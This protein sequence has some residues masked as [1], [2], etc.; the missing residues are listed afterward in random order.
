MVDDN[1]GLII[2]IVIIIL[3]IFSSIFFGVGRISAFTDKNYEIVKCGKATTGKEKIIYCDKDHNL[4]KVIKLNA[5][6]D[7][8]K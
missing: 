4:Y 3:I 2:V 6:Y 5:D 8:E 7:K 1:T